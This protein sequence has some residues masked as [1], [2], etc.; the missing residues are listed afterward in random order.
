MRVIN[1]WNIY[2]NSLQGINKFVFLAGLIVFSICGCKEETKLP[3]GLYAQI[4]IGG[5]RKY[6]EDIIIKLYPEK[7]P[8]TVDNFVG[9]AEGT[10]AF[11]DPKTGEK[12]KRPFYN[13]LSFHRVIKNFMIQGGCPLGNGRGGPGYR[14]KDEIVPG[15]KFDKPGV[16]AMANSGPNTNGSQFFI[17]V[18]ET[19]WLNG[20]HTIFG[21]VVKGFDVVREI[22]ELPTD[23]RDSP[24]EPVIIN[25]VKI[26]RIK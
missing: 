21:E 16:M 7:T 13:G 9:L 5:N 4:K 25:E 20:R 14:F 11:V 8:V 17:T 22:S 19:P 10:K 18:K 12:V 6:S 23:S 1:L 2:R 15:L 24:L 26:K 3:S